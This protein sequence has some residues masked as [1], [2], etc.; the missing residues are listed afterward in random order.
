[1]GH[2]QEASAAAVE[3]IVTAERLDSTACTVARYDAG[4]VALAAAAACD[5]VDLI[6]RALADGAVV[7]RPAAG[8]RRPKR[9][10]PPEISPRRPPSCAAPPSS[11]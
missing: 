9:R 10:P 8:S 4:L 11:R 3:L 5:A 6:G 1:M 2:H 7:S